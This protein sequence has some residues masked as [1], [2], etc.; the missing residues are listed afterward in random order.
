VNYV[1]LIVATILWGVWGFANKIAV[2]RAHPFTVQWM[3][4]LPLVILIPI[5]FYLGRSQQPA[6][7]LDG[8]ALL[9]SV[10]SGIAAALALTAMLFALRSSSPTAA[11][12]LTSAY[13]IVTATIAYFAGIEKLTPGQLL[14]IGVIIAGVILFEMSGSKENA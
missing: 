3:Y 12:A 4:A 5:W 6:T 9:W 14:A 11:L 10:V 13:P 2:D 1:L 7:N 8:S